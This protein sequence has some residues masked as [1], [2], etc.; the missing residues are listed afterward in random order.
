MCVHKMILGK[1][2]D[3]SQLSDADYVQTISE[4]IDTAINFSHYHIVDI[5]RR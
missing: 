3:S 5:A 4:S 1:F 2:L